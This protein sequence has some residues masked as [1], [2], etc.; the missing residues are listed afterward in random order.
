VGNEFVTLFTDMNTLSAVLLIVGLILCI[1]EIC[2]PGFG[3]FGIAGA[4]SIVAGVIALLA[5]GASATQFFIMLF[6]SLVVLGILFIIAVHSA[7][8][9][10][11]SKTPLVTSSAAVSEDYGSPEKNFGKLLG[12]EGILMCDCKP[13]G[14]AKIDDEEYEVTSKHEFLLKGTHV[15]VIEV[16]G[17][18]IVVRAV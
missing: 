9:G 10:L 12:K 7:K 14:R 1:V 3:V 2:V 18:K 17:Q 4:T 13:V 16:E 11:L 5:Y 6:I 8:K 15:K